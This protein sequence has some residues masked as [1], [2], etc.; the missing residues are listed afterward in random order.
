MKK[1][2]LW[3]KLQRNKVSNKKQKGI[4]VQG[5]FEKNLGDDLFIY[6]LCHNYPQLEFTINTPNYE[7][8]SHFH[9]LQNFEQK[10]G[11]LRRKLRN[12]FFIDD[13]RAAKNFA[14]YLELG[15]S[16]FI[17]P[18]NGTMGYNYKRRKI[19]SEIQKHYIVMGSNFG[20]YYSKKQLNGY[21]KFFN[22]IESVSFRDYESYEYFKDIDH[23]NYYPDVVLNLEVK[24]NQNNIKTDYVLFSIINSKIFGEKVDKEYSNFICNQVKKEIKEGNTIVFMSFCEYEKDLTKGKELLQMLHQWKDKIILKNHTNIEKSLDVIRKAKKIVAT[25]YHAMILGW[26]YRKPT[27]VIAYSKKT[28]NEIKTYFPEQQYIKIQNIGNV[29]DISYT[30]INRKLLKKL[31]NDA[32]KHFECFERVVADIE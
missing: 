7:V 1:Y 13:I 12:F 32:K 10:K 28:E 24:D 27:F 17:L 9:N 31:K 6:V 23:V 5:Y 26:L 30:K 14:I 19:V 2:N 8:F 15:G 3:Q 16:I 25:R 22:S 20:P 11:I 18:A 4:F 21:K 29:S